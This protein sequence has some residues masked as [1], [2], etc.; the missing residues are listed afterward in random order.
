MHQSEDT[1]G[2]EAVIDE[3]VF[4]DVEVGVLALQIARAVVRS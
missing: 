2:D 1:V 3:E 4:M